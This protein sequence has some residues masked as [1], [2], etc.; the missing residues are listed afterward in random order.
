MPTNL[1]EVASRRLSAVPDT[2]VYS[3]A[4]VISPREVAPSGLVALTSNNELFL[5]DPRDLSYHRLSPISIPEGASSLVSASGDE[6][7]SSLLA[8]GG[9]DGSATV[10]DTRTLD[11]VVRVKQGQS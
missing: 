7:P 4:P 5:L 2:Y 11:P 9:A 10:Y 1:H 6:S 8:C 3:L